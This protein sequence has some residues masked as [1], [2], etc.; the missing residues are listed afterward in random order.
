MAKVLSSYRFVSVVFVVVVLVN[1]QFSFAVLPVI[2]VSYISFFLPFFSW[3]PSFRN[4]VENFFR[5]F[6]LSFSHF[7]IA[8]FKQCWV[9]SPYFSRFP[10]FKNSHHPSFPLP[11]PK[12]L[13][14]LPPPILLSSSPRS[15]S[16][17]FFVHFRS[18][19]IVN[20]LLF[21][22]CLEVLFERPRNVPLPSHLSRQKSA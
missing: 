20:P 9:I 11:S 10:P 8:N 12:P 16:T 17:K 15:T 6:L 2:F 19:C 3:Q 4:V 13:P 22:S 1:V 18:A 14:V 7:S 21:R 5:L